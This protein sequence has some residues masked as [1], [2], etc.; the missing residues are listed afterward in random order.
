MPMLF[1]WDKAKAATNLRKH[2]I[3]FDEAQTVF[4][5][6]L[7]ITATD[8][9]HSAIEERQVIIGKSR[10]QRLLVVVYTERSRRIRLISARKATHQE[11]RQ[12]EEETCAE[13]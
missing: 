6:D 10:R 9:E 13:N 4:T 11:R 12:Y 1:E 3:G 7:S 5:D 2:K 8:V